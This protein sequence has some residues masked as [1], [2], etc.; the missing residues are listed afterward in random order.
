MMSKHNGVPGP[1]WYLFLRPEASIFKLPHQASVGIGADAA[2]EPC[3]EGRSDLAKTGR[4]VNSVTPIRSVLTCLCAVLLEM[5]RV[6]WPV[7]VGLGSYHGFLHPNLGIFP[8]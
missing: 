8:E 1:A 3:R 4:L 6:V 2:L 7:R 5:N